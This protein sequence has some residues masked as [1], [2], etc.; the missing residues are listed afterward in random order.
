[1]KNATKIGKIHS[2]RVK[3]KIHSYK[4]GNQHHNVKFKL[5]LIR[6]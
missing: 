1:M 4:S 5:H 6:A 3:W 2:K